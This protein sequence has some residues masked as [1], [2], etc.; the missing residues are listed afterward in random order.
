MN[1]AG[2]KTLINA[3]FGSVVQLLEVMALTL[4]CLMIFAL[5]ALQLFMGKLRHKCVLVKNG[6]AHNQLVAENEREMGELGDVRPDD[7]DRDK[8]WYK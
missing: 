3:L 8:M 7:P 2:L 5:L 6:V 1:F 4:F